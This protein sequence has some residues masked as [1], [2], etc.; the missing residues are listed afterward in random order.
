MLALDHDVADR[1]VHVRLFVVREH[2]QD[3]LVGARRAVVR[4]VHLQE[5]ALVRDHGHELGLEDEYVFDDVLR[6]AVG[7]LPAA[8]VAAA[9]GHH[10]EADVRRLADGAEYLGSALHHPPFDDGLL[11]DVGQFL[12]VLEVQFDFRRGDAGIFFH[13]LVDY[14]SNRHVVVV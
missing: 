3:L 12:V 14:L 11:R 2:H 5:S 10:G 13:F 1:A 6:A 7:D 8:E 4:A 9:R